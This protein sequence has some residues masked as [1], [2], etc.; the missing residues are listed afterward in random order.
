MFGL[1]DG[2]CMIQTYQDMQ[3]GSPGIP[4]VVDGVQMGPNGIYEPLLAGPSPCS[5]AVMAL[6]FKCGPN[7]S[8][9]G[10]VFYVRN[11]AFG[12]FQLNPPCDPRIMS[13]GFDCFLNYNSQAQYVPLGSPLPPDQLPGNQLPPAGSTTVVQGVIQTLQPTVAPS[14][15][16]STTQP[17]GTT[18][19]QNTGSTAS[20]GFDFSSLLSN[21]T[22]LMIGGGVLLLLVLKK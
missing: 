22:A 21:P 19:T 3:T 9:G 13:A 14:T 20:S 18:Q 16:V 12:G 8:A 2:G 15:P 7:T 11:P 1:G 17:T 10:G 5:A 4:C 6:G